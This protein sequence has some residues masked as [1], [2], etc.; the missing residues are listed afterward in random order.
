MGI[1]KYRVVRAVRD[2]LNRNCLFVHFPLSFIFLFTDLRLS[3]LLYSPGLSVYIVLITALLS[4]LVLAP[5]GWSLCFVVLGI[6]PPALRLDFLFIT[7]MEQSWLLHTKKFSL[8]FFYCFWLVSL[9][10]LSLWLFFSFFLTL[11]SLLQLTAFPHDSNTV[12]VN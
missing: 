2:Q 3:Q 1:M 8:N 7:M 9:L 11:F 12:S 4:D 10:S 5:L 6:V